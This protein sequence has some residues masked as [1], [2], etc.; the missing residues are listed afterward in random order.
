MIVALILTVL[1][2]AYLVV[3]ILV[4]AGLYKDPVL[5]QFEHYAEEDDSFH[6]LPSML[7]GAGLFSLTGGV[8]FS[9]TLAPRFPTIV[10][11]MLFLLAA[12]TA[13]MQ[14]EKLNRYPQIFLTFPRWY[15]ELRERT[16]REERRKIAYMWL[17]LPRSMRLHLNGSDHHFTTW[18]DQVI[19][20]TVTQTVE[21]QEAKAENR[22]YIPDLHGRWG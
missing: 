3:V 17:C 18:A 1:S 20:A 9:A 22:N 15:A 16:T 10:L 13:R 8:L 4:A 7:L 5:R 14:R 2:A 6:L 12:Y 19:L 21:D 11:G